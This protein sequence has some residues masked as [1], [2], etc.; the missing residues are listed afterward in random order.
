MEIMLG[1]IHMPSGGDGQ[2][3][4]W[5]LQVQGTL[6]GSGYVFGGSNPVLLARPLHVTIE[7]QVLYSAPGRSGLN[8]L[9]SFK[10][11]T[12]LKAE[13][14]CI[15]VPRVRSGYL[16]GCWGLSVL[17][18]GKGARRRDREGHLPNDINESHCRLL[19]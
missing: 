17:G 2:D 13:E 16:W 10:I 18:V 4:V 14:L 7:A 19:R 15:T 8:K 12:F 5:N 3:I 1:I 9:F 11:P 6:M